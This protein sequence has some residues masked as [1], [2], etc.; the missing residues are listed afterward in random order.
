MTQ[1]TAK[2]EDGH[3]IKIIRA[4][5]DVMRTIDLLCEC[6]YIYFGLEAM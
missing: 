2:H 3:E 1:I 5:D 6:G 4:Y